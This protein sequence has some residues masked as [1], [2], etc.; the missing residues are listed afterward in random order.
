[1]SRFSDLPLRKKLRRIVLVSSGIPLL[2]AW[3]LFVSFSMLGL[4]NETRLHL[5]TLARMTAFNLQAA[6]V[7]SYNKEAEKVLASLQA[8][9]SIQMACIIT[10]DNKIF[11]SVRLGE[12]AISDCLKIVPARFF[13]PLLDIQEN[14]QLDGESLGRL[15]IRASV[16]RLWRTQFEYLLVI[17]LVLLVAVL[18]TMLTGHWLGKRATAPILELAGLAREVS[19]RRNYSLRA[20]PVGHDEI[21]QLTH[22]FNDMLEQI[23]RRDQV[24]EQQRATLEERVLLR[25]QELDSARQAAVAASQAKSRFLATMSHEI[26]TP[27][28]GVLGMTELLLETDLN[29]TQRR[30]ADTVHAS[31]E[32]L[33]AIINDILDFS[34]IE[35]G[36]LELE[37]HPFSPAEVSED[38]VELLSTRAYRKGLELVCDLDDGARQTVLG[39]S[40]RLRQILVNLLGNSIKFTEQGYVALRLTCHQE[41]GGIQLQFEIRDTGIGMDASTQEQLFSPFVQADSSHARRFG[42][43]GLGLAIVKQLVTMMQGD[44]TV[45]SEKGVGSIFTLR[46]RMQATSTPVKKQPMPLTG[47]R[48]LVVDDFPINREVLKHK[49]ERL[50]MICGEASNGTEALASLQQAAVN[51]QPWQCV[52]ADMHMPD[53]NGVEL[54]ARAHALTILPAPEWILIASA[55]QPEELERAR[56]TGFFHILYKPVRDREVVTTLRHIFGRMGAPQTATA[57]TDSASP[58][59][60]AN[61]RLLLVEDTPINQMVATAMLAKLGCEVQVAADGHQAL[62]MLSNTSFDLV[63]MDCQMPELDGFAATREIRARRLVNRHGRHLPVIA[64]T[65]GVLTEERHACRAAGM[66]DFLAKPVRYGDLEAMLLHWLGTSDPSS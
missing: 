36:K 15:H 26:R 4:R 12:D 28:N 29:E 33:L 27:M 34:K 55:M 18:I 38:V 2:L 13:S 3:L 6:T 8:D 54:C 62:A 65:A 41:D 51:N 30:F 14:I 46:V 24:L 40:N 53:M 10:P 7:F 5:E 1:M 64:M 63:L 23:E 58:S 17:L 20:K 57:N 44:I 43:S 66:D 56:A 31:G 47:M 11:A 48:V 52:L 39:D 9:P 25:T 42:G 45:S 50:G 16:S 59:T 37:T 19:S 60:L 61:S 49:L 32:S 22:S 35:A 21:G